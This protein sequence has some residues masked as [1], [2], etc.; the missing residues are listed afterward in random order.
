MGDK[1]VRKKKQTTQP[2]QEVV[3]TKKSPEA[4]SR[5]TA[6]PIA[7][8]RVSFFQGFRTIWKKEMKGLFYSPIAYVVLGGFIL[9]TSWFFFETFWLR[10]QASV[11]SLF[12]NLPKMFL[13]FTPLITMRMWAEERASGTQDQLFSLPVSLTTLTLGKLA[14]CLTLILVALLF[15]LPYPIIAETYG[16]LDW[17]PVWGGYIAAFL[18]GGAYISLGLFISALTRTQI[19][20]AFIT[21]FVGGLL[22]FLGEPMVTGQITD[23]AWYAFFTKIGMGARFNSIARGV[24]DIRD[25]LYYLSITT[26]F[27]VINVSVLRHRK[28]L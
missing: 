11:R 21:I 15:T 23:P 9:L 19:E 20:A 8:R 5:K 17:G 6:I 1:K 4:K 7:P 14:A 3:E 12:S 13:I 27:V 24:L 26:F 28:W 16:N 10:N 18:L 2:Q 25:L 22:Y